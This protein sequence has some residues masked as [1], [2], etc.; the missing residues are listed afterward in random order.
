MSDAIKILAASSSNSR[1]TVLNPDKPRTKDNVAANAEAQEQEVNKAKTTILGCVSEIRNL[2]VRPADFLQHLASQVCIPFPAPKKHTHTH[3]QTPFGS[4]K[5]RFFSGSQIFDRWS[6]CCLV[7]F[8]DRGIGLSPVACGV[9]DP[10]MHPG[11]DP[12]ADRDHDPDPGLDGKRLLP[13][14]QRAHKRRGGF[15][16]R[17]REP[18]HAR[19]SFDGNEWVSP[20]AASGPGSAHGAFGAVCDRPVAAGCRGVCGRYCGAGGSLHAVCIS[21]ATIFFFFFFFLNLFFFPTS[22]HQQR[23]QQR[24]R[25]R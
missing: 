22:Q 20:R 18:T 14:D 6:F 25:Q 23:Q 12:N 16:G 17:F 10:R 13:I 11:S 19:H 9:S 7:G 21:Y 15:D 24:Q 1:R 8:T 5:V 3:T 2:V 4:A